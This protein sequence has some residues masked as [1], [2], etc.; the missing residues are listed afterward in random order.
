MMIAHHQGAIDMA[1][2]QLLHGRDPRLRR[3]AQKIIVE[4]NQEIGTMLEVLKTLP[5]GSKQ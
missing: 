1:K 3:L 2:L 4:Q 5:A